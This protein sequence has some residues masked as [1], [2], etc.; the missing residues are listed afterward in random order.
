MKTTAQEYTLFF[1][2]GSL[3]KKKREKKKERKKEKRKESM[4]WPTI[5]SG[6]PFTKL[7]SMNTIGF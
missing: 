3:P 5:Y 4:I 7:K 6:Q 1:L 2:S